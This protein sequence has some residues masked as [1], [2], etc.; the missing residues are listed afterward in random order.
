MNRKL[1]YFVSDVHL[2][3]Q[4]EDP[5]DRERRFVDFLNGLSEDTGAVYLLGDIWDFWYACDL[6]SSAS[7][8]AVN[9][10]GLVGVTVLIFVARGARMG[11]IFL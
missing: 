9:A 6:I 2:G 10:L 3:L 5:A 11:I 8:S 7:S 4:V 1:A